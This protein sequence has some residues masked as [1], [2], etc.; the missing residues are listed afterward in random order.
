[1]ALTSCRFVLAV[2]L[3]LLSLTSVQAALHDRLHANQPIIP[4]VA[5]VQVDSTISVQSVTGETLP[6][7]NTTYYFDQLVDHSDPSKGTFKQR[8]W[9][10]WE[11]Y[12]TGGPIILMTPGEVNADGLSFLYVTCRNV[13]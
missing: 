7:L 9:H 6:P 4:G 11:F 5:K 12:K 13:H 3:A 1:M 2:C 8:Y 10:T